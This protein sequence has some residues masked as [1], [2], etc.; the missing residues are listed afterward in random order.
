MDELAARVGANVRFLRAGSGLSLGQLAAR[1]G[2]A[3]STLS[4]IEAGTTNPTLATLEALA[5]ALSVDVRELLASIVA[6][7]VV[8]V[9]R[10]SGADVSGESSVGEL[11]QSA[12]VGPSVVEF[13]RLRL[14]AGT[15]EAS[16]SHGA[17]AR[18]HV[19]VESGSLEA[20]PVDARVV[21]GAGDYASYPG[22]RLHR[23]EAVGEEAASYWIVATY[24][25]RLGE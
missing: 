9:R 21:L 11:M 2:V 18:E 13:H 19:L 7:A 17:G 16:P 1:S 10:G 23:F 24:P 6:D 4:Q 14:E 20:G 5:G 3:K 8:T 15:H 25:R 22:D 12:T